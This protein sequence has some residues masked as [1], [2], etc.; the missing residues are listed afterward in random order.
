MSPRVIHMAEYPSPASRVPTTL[1]THSPPLPSP[2]GQLPHYPTGPLKLCSPEVE[3]V[4]I[5]KSCQPP[6]PH[7]SFGDHLE[8]V[9]SL[10]ITRPP[11]PTCP[12]TPL[13]SPSTV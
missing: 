6:L 11:H 7:P 4:F 10:L 5:P 13:R 3:R 12:L 1:D 8:H 2:F 9:S